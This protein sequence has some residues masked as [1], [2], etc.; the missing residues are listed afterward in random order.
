MNHD[1]NAKINY[2]NTIKRTDF[3]TKLRTIE[4]AGY[5]TT[6]YTGFVEFD[7]AIFFCVM[8][9]PEE[10]KKKNIRKLETIIQNALPVELSYLTKKS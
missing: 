5:P 6:E 10:L 9:T 1:G 3:A 4:T 8:F 7:K 2:L